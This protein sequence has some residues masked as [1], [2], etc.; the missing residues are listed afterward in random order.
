MNNVLSDVIK[1]AQGAHR[2]VL[3]VMYDGVCNLYEQQPVKDQKTKVTSQREIL[4]EEKIPCHLSFTGGVSA[5]GS[6]TVTTAPQTIK[7]FLPPG[8]GIKPGSRIEVTQQGRTGSYRRSGKPAVY[9]SHQEIMLD[10][11]EGYT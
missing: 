8:R 4:I 11:W 2:A 9:F 7:L 3:E 5:T 1:R 6:E 10:L